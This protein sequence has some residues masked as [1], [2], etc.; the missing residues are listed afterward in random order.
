MP[1]RSQQLDGVAQNA[2]RRRRRA[3]R[4]RPAARSRS[5]RSAGVRA[6]SRRPARRRSRGAGARSIVARRWRPRRDRGTAPCRPRCGVSTPLTDSPYQARARGAIETRPRWGFRPNSPHQAAGIRIEPRAVGAERRAD[7]PGRHRRP[8]A[9]ARSAGRALGVPRVARRAER[10]RLGERPEGQLGHVRLAD[11]HRAR[12]AQAADDLGVG[13]CRVAVGV[14]AERR[15]LAGDVDVVLDG[16]RHPQQRP[17]VAAAAAR[18]GLVGLQP[19]ALGEDDT[20][21]VRGRVQARDPLEVE[22]HQLA[23]G[24]LPGARSARPGGRSL[25]RRARWLHRCAI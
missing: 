4:G 2:R 9:A 18:V 6:A 22:L 17:L 24:D 19:R 20:E 13:A 25:R 3:W 21:G 5:R 14:R 1:E 10:G 11:D 16:D 15:H 23:R 12:L 7:Q 8:A